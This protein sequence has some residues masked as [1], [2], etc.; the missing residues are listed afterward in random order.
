MR[1]EGRKGLPEVGVCVAQSPEMI[2]ENTEN[3]AQPWTIG[4][5]NNYVA[6]W[7]QSLQRG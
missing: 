4:D 7:R 1:R 5:D 6:K 3:I 2:N